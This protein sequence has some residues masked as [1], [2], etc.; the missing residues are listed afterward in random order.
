DWLD[1]QLF[2]PDFAVGRIPDGPAE[3][4]KVIASFKA[5]NGQLDASTAFTAGYDF[6]ADGAAAVD[7]QLARRAAS[8]RTLISA[9]W[10]RTALAGELFPASGASPGIA[11]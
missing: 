8:H 2:V 7:A 5:A 1:H 4:Q 10:D 11:A 3:V 9:T 6:I